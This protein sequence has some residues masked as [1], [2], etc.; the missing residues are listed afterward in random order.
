MSN[1]NDDWRQGCVNFKCEPYSDN[2]KDKN[3]IM[4]SINYEINWGGG[5][6]GG[7][8]LVI[9]PAQII[10]VWCSSSVSGIELEDLM[11]TF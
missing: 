9:V 6:E 10:D 2:W 11:L 3:K 5:G 4:Y 1:F 7:V 8:V